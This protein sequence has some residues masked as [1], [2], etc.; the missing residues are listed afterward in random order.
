M[1]DDPYSTTTWPARDIATQPGLQVILLN[2]A[3]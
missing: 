3:N 1:E 2:S